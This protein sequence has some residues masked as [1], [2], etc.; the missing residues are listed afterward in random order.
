MSKVGEM[1]PIGSYSKSMIDK[2]I[3]TNTHTT[4]I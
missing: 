3:H 2:K 4:V 1:Y